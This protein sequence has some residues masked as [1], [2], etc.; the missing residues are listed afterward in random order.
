MKNIDYGK[1]P[2]PETEASFAP[3]LKYFWITGIILGIIISAV[4]N[5][6]Y[7]NAGYRFIVLFSR[8]IFK[9]SGCRGEGCFGPL[10]LVWIVSIL[11]VII[12]ITLLV[13]FLGYLYNFRKYPN[14]KRKYVIVSS[15]IL[16][17]SLYF[18][19]EILYQR[20]L[21]YFDG[22]RDYQNLYVPFNSINKCKQINEPY[23]IVGAC[24]GY[25]ASEQDNAVLCDVSNLR[26]RP[27]NRN[28][29]YHRAKAECIIGYSIHEKNPG[30]CSK[31]LTDLFQQKCLAINYIVMNDVA[32]CNTITHD[33]W[34]EQCGVGAKWSPVLK[35][36]T[37]L[38][39]LM[40]L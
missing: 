21:T 15:A 25:F 12:F 37:K 2:P 5:F 1:S 26:D 13:V 30:L 11:A 7:D 33:Y 35:G 17:T 10:I 38:R 27:N 8:A 4:A 24:Y 29:D 19:T 34:R 31:S 22:L 18:S 9:L 36:F 28:F 3:S 16:F 14:T 20:S 23:E 6:Y 40:G 39:M 32:G